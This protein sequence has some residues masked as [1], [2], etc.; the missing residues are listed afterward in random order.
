MCVNLRASVPLLRARIF[1]QA[2]DLSYN[3]SCFFQIRPALGCLLSLD[4]PRQIV[5]SWVYVLI[6][7]R[8]AMNSKMK[9]CFTPHVMMHSL[10]GLGLGLLVAAWWPSL[11]SV[12]VGVV[13]M[14]VAVALDYMRK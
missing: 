6:E 1:H 7:E 2:S 9:S 13:V 14:V 10:F 4:S 11:A 8:R 12:T 3:T 5:S